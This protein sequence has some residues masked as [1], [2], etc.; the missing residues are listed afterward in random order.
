MLDVSLWK[1]PEEVRTIR[2]KNNDEIEIPYIIEDRVL[3]KEG[4]AN[5][6]FYP[7]E[8]LE[9]QVE[10]LNEKPDPEDVKARNRTSIFWD[11]DDACKNWLGE[12]K[13]FRWDAVGKAVIG[14]IYLVDEDAAKKTH[15]QLQQDMSR[16]GISPRI[17]INEEDGKATRIQFVSFALVMEP[18][19]GPRLML[20]RT[21][22]VED[23][24]YTDL[25]L[26]TGKDNIDFGNSSKQDLSEEERKHLAK[27]F[28][29]TP[30]EISSFSAEQLELLREAPAEAIG[31]PQKTYQ[32]PSEPKAKQMFVCPRCGL[33]AVKGKEK[34]K[35]CPICDFAMDI[36]E[37]V[38]ETS[39]ALAEEGT[40]TACGYKGPVSDGKCPE[41]GSPMKIESVQKRIE[42]FTP[43]LKVDTDEHLVTM[44]VLEP[45]IVDNQGHIVSAEEI[46]S[47]MHTWMEKYKNLEVMHRDR[48]GNLFHLEGG[49]LGAEDSVWER[50]WNDEF[51]IL[52]CFQAPTDYFEGDQIVH[53]GSW[54]L[55]LRVRNEDIWQKVKNGELTGASIGGHG[56]LTSEVV[57]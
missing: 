29:L 46:R 48:G 44:I 47:A 11:H 8:E 16:W 7:G 50:G 51:A 30:E 49:P 15:Y 56:I 13:N 17:R 36:K 22:D 38:D 42:N 28:G 21:K 24:L 9:P 5:G 32:R 12:I 10:V 26:E 27:E 43:I 18:A 1:I 6:T 34:E 37:I 41:C 4:V 33:T 25:E 40:C 19:G 14:D 35:D 53:A 52:E 45:N 20:E 3:L 31:D 23:E 2:L 55:T 39:K 54:V 57:A